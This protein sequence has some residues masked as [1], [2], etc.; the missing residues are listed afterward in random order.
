MAA[1]SEYSENRDKMRIALL[2]AGSIGTIMG[3][4]LCQGGQDV[5]L[6]DSFAEHVG[7]LNQC[8][9][10]I[11]GRMDC[12]IPVRALLPEEMGGC[13]DLIISLTKQTVLRV[14]LTNALPHMHSDTV[15]LTLQN[16]I[17]ED[18]S[19]EIVEEDRIMGGGV[20]FGATWLEPGVSE[21][22]T[23]PKTLGITFGPVNGCIT[24]NTKRI[25]GAFSGL[26]HAHVIDNILG[27][28]YSKLTDNSTFS[29]MSAALGCC[30][31]D[32]LDSYEAMTCI[33][34]L[35]REAAIII[36]KTGIM[37]EKIFG[38]QP[39]VE[40]LGFSTKQEMDDVIYNY[41]TPLYTSF[42]SCKASML[43]DIEKGR[44][45]EIDYING[46][47]TALGKQYGVDTPFMECAVR[48]I[49]MLQNQEL[50]LADAWDNLK[51]FPAPSWD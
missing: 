35:G 49:T 31:G 33:A 37:P 8:G 12:T 3:A 45:C 28:R 23:D 43:Q 25:Q 38:F 46:K 39:L 16:G 32:I 2:G 41:W 17:P 14:S 30:W 44:L 36:E 26:H 21:L 18:I 6:V 5:V 20:E 40:N 11:T 47:F 48:L 4:L 42:R 19:R 29:A 22:T 51:Y 1:C 27:L 9:A 15:I 34:H 24:E 10:R 7:V 13:Y 50:P